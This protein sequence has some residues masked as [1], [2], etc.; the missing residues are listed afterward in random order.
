LIHPEDRASANEAFYKAI[1]ERRD[2]ERDL[3]IVRPN[4][5]TR[6]VH[7]LAHPVFNDAGDLT[8]YVGT[9]ID[10]TER[11]EA[12]QALQ[13]P[14]S[15]LAR[16][17]RVATLGELAASIAHEVSQPLA[18]LASNAGACLCWLGREVPDL[19]EAR[20]SAQHIIENAHRAGDV[21]KGIRSLVRKSPG[22]P[23]RLNI[24]V[25]IREVIALTATELTQNS[26]MLR[27]ELQPDI[28]PIL[29]DRVQIAAGTAESYPQQHR[30]YEWGGLADGGICDPIAG[31]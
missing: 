29:G 5:T 24:N 28:P 21:I 15:E 20:K 1:I 12:E 6:H 23:E 26:V 13:K 4:G 8:E 22:E 2:F 17:T 31:E 3:R 14:Q 18:D 27:T 16:V 9:I 25:T 30:S 10:N 19:D 7:S 11:K